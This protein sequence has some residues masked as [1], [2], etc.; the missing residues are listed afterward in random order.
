MTAYHI[1]Q[2]RTNF[3]DGFRRVIDF[4]EDR[5]RNFKFYFEK[6]VE[7]FDD[8][9]IVLSLLREKQSII[10]AGEEESRVGGQVLHAVV[11]GDVWVWGDLVDGSADQ[12][13][14]RHGDRFDAFPVKIFKLK[15]LSI[16]NLNELKKKI[17]NRINPNPRKVIPNKLFQNLLIVLVLPLLQ[18][19]FKLP[20][21]TTTNTS[22]SHSKY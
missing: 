17:K 19:F 16:L 5:I 7:P 14:Q 6:L 9:W 13:H 12:C 4:L 10:V 18:Y 21:L 3:R 8:R 2:V 15:F 11:D 20:V 1:L 22:Y